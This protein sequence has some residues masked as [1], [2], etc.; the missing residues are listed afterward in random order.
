MVDA[1]LVH[2]A[3]AGEGQITTMEVAAAA[4]TAGP[5]ALIRAAEE[6]A[7]SSVANPRC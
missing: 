2:S 5:L 7:A 1:L 3:M 6:A 4:T